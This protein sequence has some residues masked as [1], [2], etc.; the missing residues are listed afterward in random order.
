MRRFCEAIC[1]SGSAS[2]YLYA[3]L[4]FCILIRIYPKQTMLGKGEQMRIFCLA[5]CSSGSANV[6]LYFVFLS[7]FVRI[8]T[9]QTMLGKGEQMRIFCQAICSSGSASSRTLHSGPHTPLPS[10]PPPQTWKNFGFF[11]E[12]TFSK[13]PKHTRQPKTLESYKID[14]FEISPHPSPQTQDNFGI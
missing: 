2:V 7:I 9:K 13:T 10:T 8:C 11:Q 3:F 14:L 4:Y 5:I 12:K 6:Y 1:S